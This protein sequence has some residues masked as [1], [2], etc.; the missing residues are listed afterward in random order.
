LEVVLIGHPTVDV[1][2]GNL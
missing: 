2:A 1:V